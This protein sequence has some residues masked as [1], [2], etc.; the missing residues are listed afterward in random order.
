MRRQAA[1]RAIVQQR[2]EAL[3]ARDAA[4]AER[5]RQL[6][7]LREGMFLCGLQRTLAKG[8]GGGGGRFW[9]GGNETLLCV[10]RLLCGV[11]TVWRCVLRGV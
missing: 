5:Q 3:R 6:V 10:V 1:E 7:G 2:D 4:L 8:T 9:A 11:C